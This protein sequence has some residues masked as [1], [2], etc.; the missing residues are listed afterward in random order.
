M[1]PPAVKGAS[2]KIGLPADAAFPL[3]KEFT[4]FFASRKQL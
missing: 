4:Q 2:I 1:L 3:V